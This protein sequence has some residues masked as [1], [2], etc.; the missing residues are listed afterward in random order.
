[1]SRIERKSETNR[2]SIWLI[3]V[4]R[5]VDKRD[6][7]AALGSELVG[8]GGGPSESADFFRNVEDIREDGDLRA[9]GENNSSS[10][11]ELPSFIGKF[12]TFERALTVSREWKTFK[13]Y[14][15]AL[16]SPHLD[17]SPS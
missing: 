13:F 15:L 2:A 11:E 8:E 4:L 5:Y 14:N 10:E 16:D 7:S 1:M 12:R 9:F 3:E 17:A 6:S